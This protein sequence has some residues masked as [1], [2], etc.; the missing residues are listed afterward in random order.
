[1]EEKS[2]VMNVDVDALEHQDEIIKRK[3]FTQQQFAFNPKNYLDLKLQKDETSKTIKVRLLPSSPTDGNVF[4]AIRTHSMKVDTEIAKSG[5]KSFICLVDPHIGKERCPICAKSKELFEKANKER[6]E[7]N[8]AL[9]KTYYKEACSLK[10]KITY[11]VRVIDREHED[12]G[13]KFWR[14]N[15]NS[16]G[17]GVYDK[18][19]N[20]YKIRKK[21]YED[22]G[23]GSYNIF[24]LYNGKDINI[25][26][27]KTLIPDG[28]G[29]MKE[30]TALNITDAS[31]ESPLS[32]DVEK[33]NEW[34]NDPKTWKDVYS[35][36]TE[37]YLQLVVD[38]KIPFY[39]R[40]EGKYVE[41][42]AFDAEQ[43]IKE[44]EAAAEILRE[45]SAYV[46]ESED[47]LPF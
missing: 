1:M 47:K 38:G 2:Y 7:G 30:K 26:I 39:S 24:D 45:T 27:T 44:E 41:K 6:S 43:K 4:F 21:E 31:I 18:L 46:E 15:E 40:E 32:K 14:F 16:L 25:N 11:I 36:K 19:M 33:A 5:F 35:N 23:R 42:K 28:R 9:S 10:S 34:I 8:E 13:V 17:E 20:L 29:G 12:E 37:E 3:N 22:A